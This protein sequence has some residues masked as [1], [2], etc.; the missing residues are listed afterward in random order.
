M[1][2]TSH[3]CA[4]PACTGR[5]AGERAREAGPGRAVAVTAPAARL[6]RPR[7]APPFFD[8]PWYGARNPDVA[9][10]GLDPWRHWRDHGR[11]EGRAPAPLDAPLAEADLWRGFPPGARERLEALAVAERP[12]ER[13]LA[14]WS[15]AR[16]HGARGE[17]EVAARHSRAMRAERGW[18][19]LVDGPGPSL[20]AARAFART[21]SPAEARAALNALAPSPDRLLAEADAQ[22]AL[23]AGPEATVAALSDALARAGLGALTLD[24][25]GPGDE[26]PGGEGPGA[27]IDRLRALPRRW[28]PRLGGRIPRDPPLVTV[29]VPARDA[30]GTLATALGSLTAQSWPALEILVVENGSQDGTLA[31]AEAWA[32]RDPRIRVLRSREI[33]AYLARNLGLAEARGAYLTVHDADDWSHPRKIEAQMRPFLG[34]HPPVATASHWVRVTPGLDLSVWR[35]EAGFVHRNTSSLLFRTDLRERLGYWDRVR[36]NADTELYFRIRAAFGDGAVREVL[37]GVPLALGRVT[38]GSLTQR[39]GTHLAT[40]A[41]GLRRAYHEAA[42][43]WHARAAPGGLRVPRRPARRPF[44]APDAIGLGDPR[45]EPEPDDRARRSPLFDAR[46]YLETY[47]DVRRAEIDAALHYV[48]DGA[49][50]GRDP[51]PGFSSSGWRA[52]HGLTDA[53]PLLDWEDRGRPQG[54]DPLPRIPGRLAPGAPRV[55]VCGHQAEETLFG[56]ERSLLDM[57]DRQVAE[58]LAPVAVLPRILNDGYLDAVL[59]RAEALHVVPYRWWHSARDAHPVTVAALR[60]IVARERPV[61]VHVNTIVI[62]A[63]LIAARAEGVP[64]CVHVREMPP[65]DAAI[66]EALGADAEAIRARLLASA[67]RFVANSPMVAGWLDAPGRVTVR[68]NAVDPALFELA[69]EPASPIRAALIGSNLAKKGV[70][71]AV[72]IARRLEGH[73]EIRLIGPATPDLDALEPLPAGA[74]RAG[75]AQSPVEAVRQADVVLSLSRFAESFG[76]TVLEA[77]AAGRPVVAYDGGTPARLVDHGETGFVVPRGDLAAAAEA[78]EALARDPAR[79]RAMGRAGRE[80]ARRLVAEA[81]RTARPEPTGGPGAGPRAGAGAAARADGGAERTARAGAPVAPVEARPA[82]SGPTGPAGHT[83]SSDETVAGEP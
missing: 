57:L 13:I 19:M 66:R 65:D 69:V 39:R 25:E 29:V 3:G 8:A 56:A 64:T 11:A 24:D 30:E 6:L 78:L 32:A 70:A 51:G 73:V 10:A 82:P 59:A 46:W 45:A 77:M 53:N 20:L 54:A 50:G 33:G 15:L 52:A 44:D 22:R 74:V 81:D 43:R 80:R 26:G 72:E 36:V 38:P 71:D 55:L 27:A 60:R 14:A 40:Q 34:A 62:D 4:R 2:S 23:G 83:A 7:R 17:W 42:R 37:P 61:E 35:Q 1:A 67:D 75:Y 31:L 16:W 63:P 48:H 76:R 28:R 18:A 49:A 68:G 79:L 12:G 5:R 47:E 41:W 58:G 9:A 21:G